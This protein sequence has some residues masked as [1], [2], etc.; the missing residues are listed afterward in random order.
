MVA[1]RAGA[2]LDEAR[3]NNGNAAIRRDLWLDQP[4]DEDLPGMEDIDW[5]RKAVSNNYRVYYAADAGVYHVHEET[6]KQV[7]RRNHREAL[8]VKQMFP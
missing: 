3:G 8:A 2:F 7:Y 4:F 5:A 6:L 1:V